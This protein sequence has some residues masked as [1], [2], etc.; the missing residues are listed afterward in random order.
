MKQ[1]IIDVMDD[2]EIK[3]ETKGFQGKSCIEEAQFLKDL[4]GEEKARNLVP[5]YYTKNKTAIRKYLPLCG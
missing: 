1:I 3:I 2:G 5:A 4:L